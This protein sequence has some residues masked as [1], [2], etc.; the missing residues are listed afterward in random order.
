MYLAGWQHAGHR[1]SA[2]PGP[3]TAAPAR[4]GW[5]ESE[6]LHEVPT[7]A[8]HKPDLDLR[9]MPFAN[10]VF[11]GGSTLFALFEAK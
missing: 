9:R 10:I 11:W 4:P 5:D 7:F 6:G 2:I 8:I 3:R 1:T